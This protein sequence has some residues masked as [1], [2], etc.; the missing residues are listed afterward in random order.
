MRYPYPYTQTDTETDA[1]QSE[2][3]R[4]IELSEHT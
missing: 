2:Q 1:L 3:V 4:C